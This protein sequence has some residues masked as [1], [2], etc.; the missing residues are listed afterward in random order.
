M[1][2]RKS[3]RP[4]SPPS[5][6][7]RRQTLL[8][9][10]SKAVSWVTPRSSRMGA[11][12]VRPGDL[13]G[14]DG[15][16]PSRCSTTSVVRTSALTLLT[17]ATYLLSHLT[18]NLKFLYGSRRSALTVNSAILLDPPAD[19]SVAYEDPRTTRLG[20]PMMGPLGTLQ[21]SASSNSANWASSNAR[22]R[23]RRLRLGSAVVMAR[24]NNF[25]ASSRT[26]AGSGGPLST[27]SC[28]GPAPRGLPVA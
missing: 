21:P 17:P 27:S 23:K 13:R 11:K 3:A 24:S 9:Q 5:A 19:W 14:D 18:R 8:A 15:S 1:S 28:I 12:A 2:L 25:L 20:W 4:T 6:A 10:S 26:D 7:P 16:P 22:T